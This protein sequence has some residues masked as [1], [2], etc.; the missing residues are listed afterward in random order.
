MMITCFHYLM[1]LN[2]VQST[3][4]CGAPEGSRFSLLPSTTP[5]DLTDEFRLSG[6]R[7][8]NQRD[9]LLWCLVGMETCLSFCQSSNSLLK[10][11]LLIQVM[12][13]IVAILS[14][15]KLYLGMKGV[16]S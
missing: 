5:G 14:G 4:C 6:R 15:M 11:P 16:C 13:F 3:M 1:V 8:A 9:L 10:Q 7:W 12:V 2:Q